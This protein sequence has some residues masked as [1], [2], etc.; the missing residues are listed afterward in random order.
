MLFRWFGYGLISVIN[1]YWINAKV[2]PVKRFNLKKYNENDFANIHFNFY[3]CSRH[4]RGEGH[5]E[6]GQDI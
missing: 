5:C 1:L 3:G 6:N 2:E 4:C